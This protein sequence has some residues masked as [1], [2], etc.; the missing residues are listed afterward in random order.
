MPAR[1]LDN[2]R[3]GVAHCRQRQEEA[4]DVEGDLS[5]IQLEFRSWRCIESPH[6]GLCHT[7]IQENLGRQ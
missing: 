2:G 1:L 6:S 3:D 5:K 7:R 4:G